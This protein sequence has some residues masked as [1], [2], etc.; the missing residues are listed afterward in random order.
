MAGVLHA[1][2]EDANILILC[3]ASDLFLKKVGGAEKEFTLDMDDGDL[4]MRTQRLARKFS[5]VTAL[6]EGV[7]RQFRRTGLE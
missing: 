5:Q 2:D 7:F 1:K 4:W 6:I 3:L